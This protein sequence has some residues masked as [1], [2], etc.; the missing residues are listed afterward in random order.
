M[1]SNSKDCDRLGA[2]AHFCELTTAQEAGLGPKDKGN[3]AFSF[4]T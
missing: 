1:E 4:L 2:A 3:S